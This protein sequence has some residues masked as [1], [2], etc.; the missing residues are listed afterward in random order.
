MVFQ[1]D[2]HI[3]YE[4]SKSSA[5]HE[6]VSYIRHRLLK[7]LIKRQIVLSTQYEIFLSSANYQLIRYI[8][9]ETLASFVDQQ[10][11]LGA[12]ESYE[13]DILNF[14]SGSVSVSR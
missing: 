9:Y 11:V 10:I 13:W 6:V 12:V 1:I 5:N 2:L 7:I 3:C 4:T 14:Q 8:W